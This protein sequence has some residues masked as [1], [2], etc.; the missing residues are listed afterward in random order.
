MRPIATINKVPVYSDKRMT[1]INNTRVNFSDGSYA[2]VSTMEV[3]NKGE[4]FITL[5]SPPGESASGK[6][7]TKTE[8]LKAS[9]LSIADVDASLDI[10]PGGTEIVITLTG[11]KSGVDDITI[12][13]QGD[14]V[15][16]KGSGDGGNNIRM[17]GGSLV[18]GNISVGGS[19]RS[20]HVSINVSGN[21]PET[22]ITITVPIGTMTD[23]SGVVG[24]TTIGDILSWLTLVQSG[25]GKAEVGRITH[26]DLVASGQSEIRVKEISTRIIAQVSGQSEVHVESG[27][28]VTLNATASGQSKFHFNGEATDATL[29]A[30]GQSDIEVAHVTNRP[31]RS[32]S[33]QAEITVRNRD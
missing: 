26:G 11:P 7:V 33:G 5:K 3:M 9:R 15:I 21:E 8:T 31:V 28:I 20:N 25:Q 10:Q 4:G 29:T 19:F 30:S 16:L 2:D 12:K 27:K 24:K 6:S 22:K 14:E 23:V 18:I 32:R 17:A 13:Q 1:G